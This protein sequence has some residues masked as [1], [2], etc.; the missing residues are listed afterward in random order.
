MSKKYLNLEGLAEFL[1]GLRS[2]FSEQNHTHTLSEIDDYAVDSTLS[3]ASEN[4]VQNNVVTAALSGKANSSH[5]H[6]DRYYTESEIDSKLDSKADI[7]HVHTIDSSLSSTSTNPVQNKVINS[8]ISNKVPTTRTING[9]ALSSNITLSASDVGADASG[10]ANTALTNA[11]TYTDSKISA[12]VNSAPETLDTLGELAAAMEDNSDAI[13]ALEAVAAS[14]AN[15]SDLTS[16]TGNSTI[17]ITATE[18]N[19]WNTAKTHAD[20]AH[21][22][23]NAEVNQNAFSNITVGS[24]TISADTKT[25]TLTL[26][27]GTNVTIT[28]DATNDKITISSQDTTY[29][30]GTGISLSGTTFSNSGVRSVATGSTNGT[31]LVNTGGTSAEVSV[32]GLGSAAYTNSSAYAASSHNHSASNITS[33]TLP[34][35]R[36]G[37][38]ATTAAGVLTNLGITATATELNYTDGVTSNIQTQL[39]AKSSAS[40][41]TTSGSGSAYTATVT[42]ITA[43]TAGVHFVMV[44]HTVSTTT[45]PTLNVNGLGAKTIRRRISNSSTLTISGSAANWLA[46]NKPVQVAYDGIYWIAEFTRPSATDLYGAVAIE[47]GGT[48][49]TTAE[50]ALTNLGITATAS[51]LNKLDGVTATTTELNYVDGVT[52]NIQTQLNGKASSSHTHNYAGSSSAGGSATSAN[53]LA[54]ARTIT[55]AGAATGNV[56]FDGSTDVTLTSTRRGASVGQSS[57]TT[58][59]PWYKFAS[60]SVSTSYEDNLIT[61]KVSRGYS[62]SSRAVGILTAHFRTTSAGY[63]E[64]GELVWE[65]A[66]SGIDANDFVLAHNASAKPTI[67]ELWCKC[68]TQ[69]AGYHF[70]VISEN[71]RISRLSSKWTL[72][73]TWVAG[74]QSAITSGYTQIASVIATLKNTVSGNASSATKL[75][76]ARTIRTNLGSTSTASF[77][78]SANIT[79]GVT[80]TLPIANGGTG[81]TTNAAIGL[82]AYPV[83]AVYISYVSTSPASLFGGEWKSLTGVFPYFNAGTGTGGSNTH[84]LTTAQMP[85]HTHSGV[86]TNITQTTAE[87]RYGIAT[88][89]QGIEF[90]FSKGSTASTGSGSSHNNMPAYQTLYAWRRTA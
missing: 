41:V 83:G 10:S 18:R 5:A 65:Y 53:K 85:K 45:T 22:P 25:D 35:T 71:S 75:S 73:N 50:D 79:P 44:P 6:D 8:A 17:H 80:G 27:A 20:T 37:T 55:L 9:K 4:P 60:I 32:K 31:V 47:N 84:T 89:Y 56:S 48:G 30:A 13:E 42:G 2:V 81:V 51:E 38:G 33:G 77:D 90:I 66:G 21:A 11:K 24:T 29:S 78:G 54:T 58:T 14:K 57:S 76:T 3:S 61:F 63:W 64:S 34:I 86:V 23:S 43:L 7:N 15:A 69:Y 52:S 62:D 82:K 28:P 46:A 26:T 12:L 1:A 59:N 74:S 88:E 36:G 40:G 87:N 49:A 67:V 72:Y 68:D 70:D 19:N 39:D 16:H